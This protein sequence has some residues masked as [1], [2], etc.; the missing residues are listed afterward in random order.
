MHS[1][2]LQMLCDWLFVKKWENKKR[3]GAAILS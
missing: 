3:E 2:M 1:K